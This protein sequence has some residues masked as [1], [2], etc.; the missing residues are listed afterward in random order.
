MEA[1]G[2]DR[3]QTDEEKD[4]AAAEAGY[5]DG[6]H[7]PDDEEHT[8]VGEEGNFDGVEKDA[9]SQEP[10]G[11]D[12]DGRGSVTPRSAPAPQHQTGQVAADQQQGAGES[13][14]EAGA[15]EHG[16]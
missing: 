7:S 3:P 9:A 12:G 6:K 2:Q 13:D 14:G 1:S 10:I 11:D 8:Q 15:G 5:P 4:A 16:E